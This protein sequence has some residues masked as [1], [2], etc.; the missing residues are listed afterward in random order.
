MTKPHILRALEGGDLRSI[1]RANEV[2]AAVLAEPRLF[3]SLFEGLLVDDLVVRARAADAVEKVSALHPEFLLPYKAALIGELARDTQKEVR[4]HVA[5]MLPRIRWNPREQA[6]VQRILT[7]LLRD[8]SRLVKTF[9]MQGLADLAMQAP[10]LR[11]AVFRQ[12][13]TL[14]AHGSPAMRARGRKLLT[15]LRKTG[16]FRI[17]R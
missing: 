17:S 12:L 16:S 9:A 8:P 11:P 13:R 2:V 10:S 1:G 3:G 4:W 5:Q 14:T 6:K 7:E 15:T